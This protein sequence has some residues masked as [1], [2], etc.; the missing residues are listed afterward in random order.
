MADKV[1]GVPVPAV[2]YEQLLSGSAQYLNDLRIPGMLVG[3]LL[4]SAHPCARVVNLVVNTAR[5][6]PGVEAILTYKD[7]PGEN[8]L[9]IP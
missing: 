8:R 3:K 5:A 7:I 4:Y 6:I 2:Q 9:S 1:I